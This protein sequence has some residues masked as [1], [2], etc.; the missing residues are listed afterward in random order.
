VKEVTIAA[1]ELPAADVPPA[2]SPP[3][4]AATGGVPLPAEP[5]RRV[6]LGTVAGAR[7]GDKGGTC[8]LGVYTLTDDAYGW[9]AA[10]LTPERLVA[11]LPEATGLQIVREELP[12]LRAVLFQ[13]GGLLGDG[14]AAATRFDPQAKAVGEWLR[15]REVDVPVRLLD[16]AG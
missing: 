10:F 15:A 16:A 1:P 9:L 4:A 7:S 12:A 2:A 5:V 13:I 11:L 14:V 8:T 6:P 3:H